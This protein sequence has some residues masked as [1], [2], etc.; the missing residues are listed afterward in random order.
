MME[1][2]NII[3]ETYSKKKVSGPNKVIINT[4]KG[5]KRIGYPYVLNKDIRKY[6]YN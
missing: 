4:I 1:T 3:S 6:R 5:L 2:L